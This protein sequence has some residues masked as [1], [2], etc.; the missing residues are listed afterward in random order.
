MICGGPQ[1]MAQNRQKLR[2]L[3]G[4]DTRG[5]VPTSVSLGVT[6]I[7]KNQSKMADFLVFNHFIPLK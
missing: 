1:K 6:K 7:E 4:N 5:S 3:I 2:K